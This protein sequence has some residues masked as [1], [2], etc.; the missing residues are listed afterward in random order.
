[1]TYLPSLYEQTAV[2]R[3]QPHNRVRRLEVLYPVTPALQ[4]DAQTLEQLRSGR[5][6]DRLLRHVNLSSLRPQRRPHHRTGRRLRHHLLLAKVESIAVQIR[7]IVDGVLIQI[8]AVPQHLQ[9]HLG[10]GSLGQIVG[11][12]GLHIFILVLDDRIVVGQ[13]WPQQ[14]IFLVLDFFL[15]RGRGEAPPAERVDQRRVLLH[16]LLQAVLLQQGVLVV[17]LVDVVEVR[18]R[19]AGHF[20]DG[21]DIPAADCA[22]QHLVVEVVEGVLA[23]AQRVQVRSRTVAGPAFPRAQA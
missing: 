9:P 17:V 12:K 21:H 23:G 6:D 11:G 3:S 4:V 7:L 13:R 18:G 10:V 20:V 16:A 2:H 8:L 22:L 14:R 15:T 19:H 5:L 1:M